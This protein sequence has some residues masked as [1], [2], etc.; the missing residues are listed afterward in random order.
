MEYIRKIDIEIDREYINYTSV[1]QNDSARAILFHLHANGTDYP[2]ANRN[3]RAWG[4]KPDGTKVFIDLEVVSAIEGKCKLRL[5]NNILAKVG[6]LRLMLTIMEGDD[7]LSTS[8]ISIDIKESLKDDEAVE[9]TNEF[10]ALEN[11]LKSVEKWDEYFKETSGKIEEK[12]TERLNNKVDLQNVRI[13]PL[14]PEEGEVFALQEEG[15]DIIRLKYEY[16]HV[17][18]YGAKELN[19]TEINAIA[20]KT[21]TDENLVEWESSKAVQIAMLVVE[22]L[23][24]N[25]KGIYPIKFSGGTYLITNTLIC[26]A[27]ED[28]GGNEIGEI[29]NPLSFVGEYRK[30]LSNK[31]AQGTTIVPLI[32]ST[33]VLDGEV[34]GYANLFAINIKYAKK[35]TYTSETDEAG[36][37]YSELLDEDLYDTNI[38]YHGAGTNAPICNNISFK[39]L[40]FYLPN[41]LADK[42]NINVIKAYRTRFTIDNVYVHNMRQFML[43][44]AQ[45]ATGGTSYC[46]FSQYTNLNFS[47]LKYRGLELYNADNSKIEDITNHFP[48][49]NFDSLVLIR[50]GGGITISRIH[51]AYSFDLEEYTQAGTLV[52]KQLGSGKDGTKAYIK[53]VN[54]KGV[55][56]N[57]VYGERQLLDYLFYIYNSKNVLI[58]NTTEVF[59][60]NGYIRLVGESSNI[61]LRNIYR[62]CNLVTDYSDIYV[63]SG[64]KLSNIAISNFIGENWYNEDIS[65]STDQSQYS[66][67]TLTETPIKRDIT[68]NGLNNNTANNFS[69]EPMTFKVIN[70]NGKLTILDY[71]NNITSNDTATETNAKNE[72]FSVT[73]DGYGI[74]GFIVEQTKNIPF[75]IRSVTPVYTAVGNI[76]LPI[77]SVNGTRYRVAMWDL[78]NNKY[79]TTI[80]V[81]MGFIINIEALRM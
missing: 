51:F 11:S 37:P 70:V 56:T 6:E 28:E 26:K 78:V 41:S 55:A 46:D 52:P 76:F 2:L 69:L 10:T 67:L 30:N 34:E 71:A 40:A 3:V 64:A 49:K 33:N 57:G 80:S 39:N 38:A 47:R 81:N 54:T 74:G 21:F 27:N 17:N 16:G 62:K 66:K 72:Y 73:W 23:A 43:Q 13:Y 48:S 4:V 19:E 8:P 36:K 44:P 5:T 35:L 53:L 75:C 18:R 61:C 31:M 14:L 15:L 45:D 50:G 58:E 77:S 29:S 20:N 9:S 79:E 59:F 42:Y 63:N 12:Y 65:L 24:S 60:G 32:K 68:S 1:R 25:K 7:I 22:K